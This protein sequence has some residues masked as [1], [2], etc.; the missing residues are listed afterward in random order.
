MAVKAAMAFRLINSCVGSVNE[1]Q[2]KA[3]SRVLH[4]C[5]GKWRA[6]RV[7]RVVD[8][9]AVQFALILTDI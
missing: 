1:G 4:G 8:R 6:C 5:S 9:S 7:C 3:A 2:F